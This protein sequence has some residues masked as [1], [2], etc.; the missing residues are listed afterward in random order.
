MDDPRDRLAA[1]MA[2]TGKSQAA[3]AELIGCAQT[4][5]SALKRKTKRLESLRLA[6]AIE[7]ASKDWPEGPPIL[8]VEWD[9]EQPIADDSD[10]E[11]SDHGPSMARSA[12]VGQ[13]R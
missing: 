5:V 11:N 2:A 13:S 12:L 9:H 7:E 6:M 4:F 1:W 8:A 3:V 10:G